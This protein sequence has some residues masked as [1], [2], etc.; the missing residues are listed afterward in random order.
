M[1]IFGDIH[2]EFASMSW[3][4]KQI[5]KKY[6]DEKNVLCCGDFGYWPGRVRFQDI[7]IPEDMKIYFCDGNHERHDLLETFKEDSTAI[8]PN[9]F[10]QKRGSVVNIEG[11]QVLFFGG[12]NSIDKEWR[13][14]YLD[15]F[16][17]ENILE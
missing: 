14:P 5:L 7:K 11:K 1:I 4:I 10:Y 8:V 15:W 3:H 13:T 12:A 9:V 16:P 6:P 2:G 17:E